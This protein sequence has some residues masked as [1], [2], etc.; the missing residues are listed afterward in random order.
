MALARLAN[1]LSGLTEPTAI[2]QTASA[3]LVAQLGAADAA[4]ALR[5]PAAESL[6]AR[7]HAGVVAPDAV[8]GRIAQADLA[9]CLMA[10]AGE[11][12]ERLELEGLS[13]LAT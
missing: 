10:E 4:L 6:Q 9:R 12:V 2:G 5:D 7:G 13:V 8:L 11:S 3:A 1:S